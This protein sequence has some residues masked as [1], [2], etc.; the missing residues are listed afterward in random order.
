[1]PKMPCKEP[2]SSQIKLYCYCKLPDF[3]DDMIA[4]DNKHCR[5]WFYGKC[6]L[7]NQHHSI[8]Q[9][10]IGFALHAVGK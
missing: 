6:F 1:M 3:T 4:S 5:K 8:L 2:K 10:I 9:L 7:T